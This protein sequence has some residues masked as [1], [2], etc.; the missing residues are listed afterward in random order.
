MKPYFPSQLNFWVG[1]VLRYCT[2]CIVNR[3]PSHRFRLFYYRKILKFEIGKSSF[4]FMDTCFDARKNFVMGNNSV[5]NQ[6]CRIDNRVKVEIG[7]NVSISAEVCILTTDH[8]LQSPSFA[9]RNKPVFVGDYVFIGTRA[10]ILAGVSLGEG[11]AVAAGA[12]VTKDVPPYSIVA[13]V[14]ARFIKHRNPNLSYEINYG[15]LFS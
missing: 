6:K 4:I 15:R 12:V 14:P 10:L 7:N 9:G 1:E 13:G 8:D 5:I 3:I 2:N 11:S